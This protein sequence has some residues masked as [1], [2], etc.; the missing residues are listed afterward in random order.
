MRFVGLFDLRDVL[1]DA[2]QTTR[3]T[4]LNITAYFL[5]T[6]ITTFNLFTKEADF[7]ENI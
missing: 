5:P 3:L 4:P 6:R 2:I 7:C 1:V